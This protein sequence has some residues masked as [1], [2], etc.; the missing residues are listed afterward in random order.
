MTDVA[1]TTSKPRPMKEQQLAAIKALR[2][3]LRPKSGEPASGETW[4]AI[5]A[6]DRVVE[7]RHEAWLMVGKGKRDAQWRE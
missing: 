3:I 2:G 7:E 6:E 1:A 4:A 5:R